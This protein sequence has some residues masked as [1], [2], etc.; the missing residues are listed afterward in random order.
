MK[1]VYDI[2]RAWINQPSSLQPLHDLH[3]ARVLLVDY[4]QD[5][6]SVVTYFVDNGPTVSG[7]YPKTCFS[8]GW[9]ESAS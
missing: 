3:G 8:F 2:R 1:T 5:S 9:P 6:A 7:V 4:D